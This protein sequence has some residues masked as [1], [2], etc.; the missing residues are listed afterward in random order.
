MIRR[1]QIEPKP[2]GQIKFPHHLNATHMFLQVLEVLWP[3]AVHWLQE[4]L[5]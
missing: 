1:D 4:V 3:L 5:Q 2:L